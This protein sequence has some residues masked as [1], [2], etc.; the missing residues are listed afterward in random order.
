MATIA[1]ILTKKW[2]GTVWTIRG[3]SYNELVWHEE[4]TIIKPTE[5]E[6]RAFDVEISLELRWDVI[7]NK[8]NKLLT[9]CDW[10][11]LV[12][13]PLS[14]EQKIAWT[15]YRQQLRDVPQQNVEPEQVVWPPQ[16]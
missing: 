5:E 8:R 6:I 16:P 10:T 15:S 3:D 4:N 11:Q 9:A 12:D 7:R 1:Q 14:T 13:T 2:P